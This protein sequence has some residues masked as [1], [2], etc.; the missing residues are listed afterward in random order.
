M[1]RRTPRPP[2]DLTLER[3]ARAAGAARVAGVDEVGRGPLAGPVMA[4][5]VILDP[6]R[7]PEGL[8]DSKRL[9]PALREALAA[10]LRAC[11][12]V[13]VAEAS[14]EEI[15]ALNV[16]GATALAMARAVA[17]LA[18]DHALI[19]GALVPRGLPCP[20]E[21]VVRGDARSASIAAASI[22]AK[23]ARDARMAALAQHDPRYGWATNMGY[24]TA[25]HHAAL[26]QHGITPHHRRS[27]RPIR[28]ML[29]PDRDSGAT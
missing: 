21:A 11:A 10:A 22:A 13:S 1:A 26:R 24:P 14:V 8:A 29:C 25:L 6:A 16:W 28:E 7:V 23:V 3:A 18:P 20:A 27:F 4:A 12:E 17:A 9:S 5:A 15:D 2:P 19:D